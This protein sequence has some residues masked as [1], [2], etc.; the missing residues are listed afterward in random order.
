MEEKIQLYL[1]KG[2]KEVWIVDESGEI[3]Y[4]SDEG[5]IQ[6]SREV[7]SQQLHEK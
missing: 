7:K 1:A 2:A 5:P 6:K 4:L 3:S